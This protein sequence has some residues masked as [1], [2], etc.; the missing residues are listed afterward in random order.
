MEAP[1]L[2]NEGLTLMLFGMGFVFV[3]LTLLVFATKMMSLLITQYEKSVG[4]L[5]E[6]GIPSPTAV[7]RRHGPIATAGHTN[8]EDKNLI[9]VLTAA[10]LEYRSRQK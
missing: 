3:F 6:G 1:S 7:I 9:S 4:V 8:K 10:V 5:P 2:L